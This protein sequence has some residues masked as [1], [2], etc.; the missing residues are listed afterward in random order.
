MRGKLEVK[1][2]KSTATRIIPAHA[3]QTSTLGMTVVRP[4][5]HPRA[6][7]ANDD[8]LV[9]LGAM[10]GSSPRMRGKRCVGRVQHPW[11]RIIPAHA[12][13]TEKSHQKQWFAPDHPRACGA[14][15]A[16]NEAAM[17]RFGSSPRMRGKRM[18]AGIWQTGRRI[19]PAHAG[20]TPPSTTRDT[21]R[22]DHPRACGA[23]VMGASGEAC[24]VGSS[25]RMRGKHLGADRFNQRG[26]IIPAHAGQTFPQLFCPV[27]CS[28]HPRACGANHGGRAAFHA[29]HGSSPRMRG[30]LGQIIKT[31]TRNRIIPAHAGQTHGGVIVAVPSTDHPR[32][33]GANPNT[34]IPVTATAGSSPRMRGKP[35]LML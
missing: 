4:S 24:K 1:E 12:G 29:I 17:T 30:K 13:Q 31:E 35:H 19:I 21:C 26:R 22:P 3:G 32:A 7:G 16:S 27:F 28:D 14:N 15:S 10:V 20:Q 34:V 5:D 33:C 11:P 8:F 18:V 6:C 25:P 23:N 9:Q 2:F